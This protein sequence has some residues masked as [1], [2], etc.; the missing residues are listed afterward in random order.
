MVYKRCSQFVLT[1]VLILEGSL[2]NRAVITGSY[3][4]QQEHQIWNYFQNLLD[5][6]Y[7]CSRRPD[8]PSNMRT[9]VFNP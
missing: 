5:F 7:T 9:M 4:H 3:I 8:K 2:E 1:L 6:L